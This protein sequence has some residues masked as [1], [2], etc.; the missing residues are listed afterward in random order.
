[1]D[2]ELAE[3]YGKL[4]NGFF[5][6]S[7]MGLTDGLY[8]AQRSKGCAMVQLGAY[9]AEPTAT[10]I[11]NVAPESL[12]VAPF[13]RST[14]AQSVPAQIRI[15]CCDPATVAVTVILHRLLMT[16]VGLLS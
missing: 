6:S 16:L 9:L 12:P 11:S 10:V 8:C 7:M 2:N 1:M 15:H 3:R 5:L 13:S 4:R 14:F